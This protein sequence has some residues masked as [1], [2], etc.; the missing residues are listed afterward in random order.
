MRWNAALFV[1]ISV[2]S[3]FG[4][5]SMALVAGVWILDL[6]GSAG[7][8]GVV[9]VFVYAPTLAAPLFGG[10]V[11]RLPRKALAIGVDLAL[12]V[13]V[14]ALL[15]VR[16]AE[17]VWIIYA[18]M[19]AY[20]VGHV[21]SGAAENALLPAAVDKSAL[22]DVNGWQSSAREGMKLVAPL[23]GAAIYSWRGGGAAALVSAVLP[24]LAA[25]LYALVRL[26]RPP[27][28]E[29]G[30]RSRIR[31]GIAVLWGRPEVRWPVVVAA[32]AIGMSGFSTAAVYARVVGG[33]GLPATFVG[34][35]AA[36]Q[37]A[38]SILGGLVAGR[39]I[40]RR[41]A[42]VAG[43]IG[44]IAFTNPLG[45]AAVHLGAPL[46]LGLAITVS[47]AAC[48]LGLRQF[49][50]EQSQFCGDPSKYCGSVTG[51]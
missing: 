34:V 47:A 3:G 44:A 23:A 6:T 28:A 32:L 41:G 20:G 18:V 19:L 9:G 25:G 21:L 27:V 2:V 30:G 11:D 13:V 10:L 5:T 46:V 50:S 49:S 12:G 24:V 17:Q 31:D 43:A 7:W 37:G 36:G 16:G 26:R 4:S 42:L 8:A 1:G 15:L 48:L 45:A 35:M 51:L 40:A 22:G 38:G 39:L 14:A 33:L 29:H